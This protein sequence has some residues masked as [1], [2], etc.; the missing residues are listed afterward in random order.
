MGRRTPLYDR[1]VAAGAAMVEFAGYD[2]PQQYS[3]IRAEHIAVRERAGIF[4]V[5]HMG[6][7]MI[8]GADAAATVRR[9]VAN[10]IT[11]LSDGQALYGVM[12]NPQGGIVDD[13]IVYRDGAD[14][15]MVVVNA[16][17][18]DK[19]FAWMVAHASGDVR[20]EDRSDQ[21]SLLAVQGPRAF[22]VVAGICALP[23]DLRPFHC[24]NATVAGVACRVSRTGYTGEDGVELYVPS[25]DATAVW[26]AVVEAGASV[27]LLPCGLGARDTLRLEAGLRLYGQDMDEN[28]DPFSCGLAWTVKMDAGDFTGRD[29]LGKLD[30]Q[31]PPRRFVGLATGPKE[32]PRH[33]ARAFADGEDVG[34]VTSG[35]FSFTLGHGI[36]TASVDTHVRAGVPLTIEVRGGQADA[37]RVALPFYRRPSPVGG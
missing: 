21:F 22:G 30:P 29:A 14:E 23:G 33:G 5:S 18:R 13:V 24:V 25:E 2:M 7:V 20:V 31:S 11:R 28:T 26:D 9:L 4:D 6:E 36:A 19:D 37:Q 35:G 3:S 1:H 34:E 10:D 32:I 8:S 12:C 17:C 27:D 15:Y 16:A